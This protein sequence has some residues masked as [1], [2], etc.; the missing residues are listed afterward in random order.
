MW[1]H[2]V[3]SW[4][5]G[6]MTVSDDRSP[7]QTSIRFDR[8]RRIVDTFVLLADTMIDEYDVIEFLGTLA[9]RCVELLH[10]DE[11]GIMLADSQ[12]NLQAVASSSERTHLLELFEL[13]NEEGPCLDAF[14]SGEM[15]TSTDLSLDTER[16]P[17]FAARARQVG[18]GAVVSLPLRCAPRRHRCP[19]PAARR[20]RRAR[21]S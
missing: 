10:T 19:Q 5:C 6:V 18:F 13:Q 15:I 21:R 8:E 9:G 12:G 2:D 4:T 3:C 14:R 20:P 17:M 16:W 1:W 7:E 11:A